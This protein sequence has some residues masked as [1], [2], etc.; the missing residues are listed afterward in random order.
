MRISCLLLLACLPLCPVAMGQS[1]AVSEN[2]TAEQ[3][4]SDF[5]IGPGVQVSNIQ[6]TGDPRALGSFDG[7]GTDFGL[8]R[9]VILS[10]GLAKD[11]EGPNGTPLSDQ[12][13]SFDL[14]GDSVLSVLTGSIVDTRDADILEFDFQLPSDTV[15]LRYIF[16]SNEYMVYVGSG[17]NDP[18][19]ILL[20]GPGIEDEQNLALIPGTA[21][22]VSIDNVN[23]NVNAQFYVDNE[24]PPGVVLEYNGHTSVFTASAI[25]M[26]NET[27]HVR[28]A[29]A[30]VGDH[31]YDTA[32]FLQEYSFR[33][34]LIGLSAGDGQLDME[35]SVY[36]NPFSDHATLTYANREQ[37]PCTLTLT[38]LA[39]Q[40]VSTIS[41][42]T[43]R[44]SIERGG[45]P[46]GIYFYQ[47][48]SEDGRQA[49]GKLVVD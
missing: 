27:Y 10:S 24:H 23:A 11:A 12:G 30:D 39:G 19:A 40:I 33:G 49:A 46:T 26:P 38:N 3:L 35:H 9:G 47:L 21:T 43:G 4:V 22:P 1:L 16:A 20:S 2:H 5:L 14:P 36:P 42:T 37:R 45:L 28:L 41:N 15:Y 48:F 18:F 44:I 8:A 31:L 6:F 25:I 32:V 29:I 13:T 34:S 17:V 7:S